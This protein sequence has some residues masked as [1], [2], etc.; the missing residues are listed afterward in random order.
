MAKT[1][2]ASALPAPASSFIVGG[3]VSQQREMMK[4]F[5]QRGIGNPQKEAMQKGFCEQYVKTLIE[6]DLSFTFGKKSGMSKLFEYILPSR[7]NVPSATIASCDTMLLFDVLDKN[8]TTEIK[9]S[10]AILCE[11]ELTQVP[12]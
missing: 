4:G 1:A 11:S 3:A 10:A 6:D 5:V 7:L 12:A 2:A 9:V 8:L